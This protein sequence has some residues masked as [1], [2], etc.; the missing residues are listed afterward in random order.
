MD[1]NKQKDLYLKL[2]KELEKRIRDIANAKDDTRFTDILSMVS[3]KN[4]LIDN[5]KQIILDLYALRNI[6]SHKDREKY[7]AN[8]NDLAFKE[9]KNIL[10]LLKNPPK[11]GKIF[12][13]EVFYVKTEDKIINIIKKMAENLYTNVPVYENNKYIGTF[14]ENSILFLMKDNINI[15]NLSILDLNKKYLNNKNEEI[16]FLPENRSIFDV[17]KSFEVSIKK[18]ERL[19]AIFITKNGKK[20]EFPLGIITAYDLPKIDSYLN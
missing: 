9:L 4:Y 5:K 3:E 19:G 15:E 10:Y 17:K 14:S 16:L 8:I 12:K 7:I 13:T 20:N 18:K 11:I 1:K 6:F 2:F